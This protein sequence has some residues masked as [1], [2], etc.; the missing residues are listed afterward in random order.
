MEVFR[1]SIKFEEQNM[2]H[3]V[4]EFSKVIHG[5]SYNLVWVTLI[6]YLFPGVAFL[7]FSRKRKGRRA[8]SMKEARENEPVV[9]GRI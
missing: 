5:W 8:R 9:L 1:Q 4:P 2:K 6:L 7:V 3:N